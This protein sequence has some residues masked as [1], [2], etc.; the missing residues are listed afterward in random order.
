[1]D[2]A[3]RVRSSRAPSQYSYNVSG[4]ARAVTCF[5]GN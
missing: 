5:T 2:S 3:L 1:M 4:A